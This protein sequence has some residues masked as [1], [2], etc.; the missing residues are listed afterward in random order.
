MAGSRGASARAHRRVARDLGLGRRR[1]CGRGSRQRRPRIFTVPGQ[2]V[3]LQLSP[4]GRGY[5][6]QGGPASSRRKR[7]RDG[8]PCVRAGRFVF[9][10]SAL[11][12]RAVVRVFSQ[13]GGGL[14]TPGSTA[15][16]V[17]MNLHLFR[18]VAR[19]I[20]GS[21]EGERITYG[22]AAVNRTVL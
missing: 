14:R 11:R 18:G 9:A 20:F 5:L 21:A 7:R 8:G 16:R 15:A 17:S 6:R 12:A 22:Y 19:Q 1:G 2:P 3:L 10:G 13:S 4:Y